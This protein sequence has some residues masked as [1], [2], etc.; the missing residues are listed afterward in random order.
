MSVTRCFV[1]VMLV[2]A[3][4]G[5]VAGCSPTVG[6]ACETSTACGTGL[7]CDL[8]TPGG[9]CTRSPCRAGECPEE[10][11]CVDFGAEASWCMRR[12]GGGEGCR[13]GL[14]CLSADAIGGATRCLVTGA[15]TSCQFCAVEP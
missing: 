13:D 6:D 12:C 2:V 15:E 10:A 5:G 11:V 8:A 14:A 4:F 1:A 3:A 9:Y 7:I